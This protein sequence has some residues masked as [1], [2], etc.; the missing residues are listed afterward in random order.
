MSGV[1]TFLSFVIVFGLLVI[2]HEFGHFI[3]ARLNGV[4][5]HEF[6]IGM[7]PQ[8]FAKESGLTKYTVR[9]LPLGGYVQLQ[10]ENEASDDPD[11]FSMK[12]PWQRFSI[13]VAG[14]LMNFLLAV[15]L[16]FAVYMMVG[17]PINVVKEV[18]PGYPAAQAG[19]LPGDEVVRVD[20][21]P[22]DSWETLTEAV[23]SDPN[24]RFQVV[25]I[26]Q[27]ETLTLEMGTQAAEG[28]RR[29]IGILHETRMSVPLS[30]VN[31]VK[32][33][34]NVTFGIVDFLGQLVKGQASG[35]GVV[36]PVGMVG[37]VGEASRSG[38]ADLMGVAAMISVNLGIFN[39]LPF[40]ALDGGRLLF[41]LYEMIFRKP[42]NRD[43]E[44]QMH[45]FGFMI[46]LALMAF[47]VFK[48]LKLLPW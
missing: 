32:T 9:A 26:R 41:V 6:S 31:A 43:W 46:L 20:G 48:D 36:G 33:T 22:V 35:D 8:L 19:I 10:G 38:L 28:G 3:L 23:P 39:L 34:G 16:F 30:A 44:Q 45:Y 42:F 18:L 4:R 27:G 17:F 47:M 21:R 11:S 5:V 25:V 1:Q 40:P 13:L 7:G 14:S 29:I 37:I 24:K 15:I 12:K 2:S